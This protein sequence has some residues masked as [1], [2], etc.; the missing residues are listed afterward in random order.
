MCYNSSMKK[1][2]TCK[3]DKSESEFNKNQDRCRDCSKSWYLA[4]SEKHKANAALAR[5][6][7]RA[8]NQE[9]IRQYK[10]KPCADCGKSYPYYVM[11]FDHI[12]GTKLSNIA[13]MVQYSTRRLLAEIA[14]CEVVCSNCHRIRTYGSESF[15]G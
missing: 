6:Q 14:K 13:S 7:H 2:C 5:K 10:N 8:N 9:L 12:S 11:D 15:S 1:C 4:N 3:L